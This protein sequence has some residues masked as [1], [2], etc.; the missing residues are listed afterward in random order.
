MSGDE[1]KLRGGVRR[2]GRGGGVAG[3][4]SGR[5]IHQARGRRRG[6][7]A[8]QSSWFGN[9]LNQ[10]P[11]VADV[12]DNQDEERDYTNDRVESD[13]EKDPPD[14]DDL[15]P[16]VYRGGLRKRTKHKIAVTE[17]QFP[18][19]TMSDLLGHQFQSKA[20]LSRRQLD[21]FIIYVNDPWVRKSGITYET[22]KQMLDDAPRIFPML[23]PVQ[24][25]TTVTK[26]VANT[27]SVNRQRGE[28][29]TVT[30]NVKVKQFRVPDLIERGLGNPLRGQHYKLGI[31]ADPTQI[32]HTILHG[33]TEYRDTE[34][35]LFMP[36]T[37]GDDHMVTRSGTF[38]V[39]TDKHTHTY[40]Q[41]YAYIYTNIPTDRLAV[42][43]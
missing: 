30:K 27:G 23:V 37:P 13:E 22:A 20:C 24:V 3:R 10:V 9:E 26:I 5:S 21:L 7:T 11:I 12:G 41:Y 18:C 16:E 28:K 39:Y 19:D 2:R 8:L 36:P 17:V 4:G 1:Q 33:P 35:A 32:D 6:R 31:K 38:E 43:M 34:H 15:E 14:D 29:R 40:M 25:K 42:I